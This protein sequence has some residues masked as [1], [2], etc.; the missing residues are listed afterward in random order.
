MQMFVI[1]LH[2][3]VVI[4]LVCIV[5]IQPSESNAFDTTSPS[6]FMSVRS[7]ANTLVRITAI[8]AAFFFLTSI[9]LAVL[10]RYTAL[11]YRDMFHRPVTNSTL[12]SPIEKDRSLMPPSSVSE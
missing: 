4:G 11:Q 7:S 9:A 3:L 10:S 6:R 1:I 5:L 12:Q 2:L 8:L